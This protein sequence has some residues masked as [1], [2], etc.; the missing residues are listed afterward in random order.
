MDNCSIHRSE[1]VQE[2]CNLAGV[3]L[4]YLPPYAPF[5]NLIEESFH[6]FKAYIHK[7]YRWREEEGYAGFEAF[8]HKAIRDMGR[9]ADVKK[10][11]RAHFSHSG[12]AEQDVE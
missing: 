7:W 1:R 9:G 12:Y 10:R 2:L 3:Q 8:L 5:L 4:E 11:A 6:D